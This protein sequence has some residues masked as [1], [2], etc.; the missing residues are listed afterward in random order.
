[1]LFK[2]IYPPPAR[3]AGA[4]GTVTVRIVFDESGK[5]IWARAVSGHPLLQKAAEDAAWHTT[6]PPMKVRGEPVKVSG[7]LMYNFV[8]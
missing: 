5:V 7:V 4:S 3:A 1:M 2:P 8:P 6:F